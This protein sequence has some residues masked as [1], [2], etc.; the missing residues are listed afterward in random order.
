[1]IAASTVKPAEKAPRWAVWRLRD[2]RVLWAGQTISFLGNS[3]SLVAMPLLILALTQS[4]TL[5]GIGGALQ[6]LPYVVVSLPA[7]VVVDRYDRR[8]I[9]IVADLCR[10]LAMLS[11]PL[12]FALHHLSVVQLFAVSLVEGTCF[13]FFNLA[14]L[15]CIRRIVPRDQ[16]PM[17][18]SQYLLGRNLAEL[19]GPP[20]GGYI[21]QVVSSTMPFLIDGISY[22]ASVAS[23]LSLQSS[24]AVTSAVT[25]KKALRHDLSEGMRWLWQQPLIRFLAFLTG[26][27]NGLL[28]AMPLVLIILAKQHGASPAMIGLMFAVFSAGGIAGSLLAPFVQKWAF[29]VILPLCV[30]GV[31]LCVLLVAIAPNPIMLGIAFGGTWAIAPMYAVTAGSYRLA[32][33]PDHL[34]GRVNSA[35]TLISRGFRPLSMIIV[36]PLIQAIG[37]QHTTVVFGGILL[38]LAVVAS[39]S[40]LIRNAPSVEEF[41]AQ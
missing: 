34:Q 25:P 20:I 1:M 14:E 16:L 22:V 3:M 40:H 41:D 2:Y 15:A 29:Q 7:G 28:M 19:T 36:G 35:F 32:V 27:V 37:A 33:I 26:I 17:A 8:T 39:A 10:A 11:I 23:L 38:L 4:P 12:A 5:A 13:V 24:F 9:M 31:A 18:R 30:W 6:T 21:I